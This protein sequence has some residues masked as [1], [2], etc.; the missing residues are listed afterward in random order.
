MC[1]VSLSFRKTT[2]IP[3]HLLYVWEKNSGRRGP[4][5]ILLEVVFFLHCFERMEVLNGERVV[6][7]SSVV[8]AVDV[9]LGCPVSSPPN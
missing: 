3:P 9:F 5:D 2:G 8:Q 6:C 1:V 7:A 4:A